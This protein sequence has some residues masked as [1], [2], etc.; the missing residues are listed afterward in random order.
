MLGRI[1]QAVEHVS[2]ADLIQM[3]GALAV[4]EAGGPAIDMV[5][6]RED[7]PESL[8]HYKVNTCTLTKCNGFLAYYIVNTIS[9]RGLF[10]MHICTH[11]RSDYYYYYYYYYYLPGA[12]PII[13][14]LQYLSNLSIISITLS[15]IPPSI[16]S[17]CPAL[18]HPFLTPRPPQTPTCA[19]SSTDWDSP[20]K[21]SSRSVEPTH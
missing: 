9:P 4:E 2:W 14:V 5:Y 16:M 15:L 3:A 11:G 1:K 7:C 10:T 20:T 6:G 13:A 17:G 21:R 12:M 19:P 8:Y 18:L